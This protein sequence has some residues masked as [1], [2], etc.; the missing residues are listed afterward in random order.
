MTDVR[1]DGKQMEE[2]AST[3]M[4]AKVEAEVKCM[5]KE[6]GKV[7]G[8][9]NMFTPRTLGM[10]VKWLYEEIEVPTGLYG[11]QTWNTGVVGKKWRCLRSIKCGV[12]WGDRI[13][14]EKR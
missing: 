2:D 9:K 10:S 3:V 8:L 12:K 4:G 5:V 13:R 1:M 7:L 11:A 14:N 6:A